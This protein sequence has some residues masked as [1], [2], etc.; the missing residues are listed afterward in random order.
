VNPWAAQELTLL[1]A[2]WP[3]LVHADGTNWCKIPD[4]V[5]PDGWNTATA[6]IAF[7]IPENL[8]GQ[9]PYGFLVYGGLLLASGATV[10]N[11]TFP[12]ETPPWADQWG[13]FSWS[14]DPWAPGATPGQGSSMIDF[15]RSFTGRLGQLN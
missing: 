4:F 7:Q 2:C 3:T 5:V 9:E 13:Q 14:L 11:Y 15:V 10:T 6:D 1:R 8:P 12:V